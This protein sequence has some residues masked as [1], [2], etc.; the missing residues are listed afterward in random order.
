M[1]KIETG[2]HVIIV[3]DDDEDV[4]AIRR[5]FSKYD[6]TIQLKHLSDGAKAVDHLLAIQEFRDL[7]D[8]ILLDINMPRV[9]GFETLQALRSSNLTRHLP[10][11]ILS[12]SDSVREI[13]QAYASGANAHMG[14][15]SSMSRLQEFV[16]AIALFW[17]DTAAL[18]NRG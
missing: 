16:R 5:A 9:N 18:P 4:F 7:P 6:D 11:I 14:K 13:R 8:L 3:D 15:P 17:L 2:R 1:S 10:I 12:T